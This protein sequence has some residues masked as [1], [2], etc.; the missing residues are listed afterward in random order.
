VFYSPAVLLAAAFVFARQAITPSI[1]SPNANAPPALAQIIQAQKNPAHCVTGPNIC[2]I[3]NSQKALLIF[4]LY[5]LLIGS[6]LS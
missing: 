3:Y 5:R 6:H 1:S 4:F 2:S